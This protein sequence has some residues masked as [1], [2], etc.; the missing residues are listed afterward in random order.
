M[1]LSASIKEEIGSQLDRF[2]ANIVVVPESSNLVLDY[3]GIS[4]SGVSFDVRALTTEDARRI[5]DIRYRKRLS[6]VAP[7]LLGAVQIEG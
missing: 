2:G 7:K 3:G 5:H 6:V 1:S 4:V